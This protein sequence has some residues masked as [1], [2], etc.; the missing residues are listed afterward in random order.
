[1]FGPSSSNFGESRTC[2]GRA[3]RALRGLAFVVFWQSFSL[4][5]AGISLRNA[6]CPRTC[7]ES[8]TLF[9]QLEEV[10]RTVRELVKEVAELR[11][12]V[13]QMAAAKFTR[14]ARKKAPG[15]QEQRERDRTDLNGAGVLSRIAPGGRFRAKALYFGAPRLLSCL[16][17]Q[18]VTLAGCSFQLPLAHEWPY[19]GP[20]ARPPLDR[21]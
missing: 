13:A 12:A 3:G 20:I 15:R 1:V 17:L 7:H 5:P 11:Q 6:A 2:S 8:S 19:R 9:R 18:P 14:R 21:R 4:T 16:F 10:R